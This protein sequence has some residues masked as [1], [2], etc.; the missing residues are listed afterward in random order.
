MEHEKKKGNMELHAKQN[1]RSIVLWRE[2]N[3]KSVA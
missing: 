2:K 3:P 1:C